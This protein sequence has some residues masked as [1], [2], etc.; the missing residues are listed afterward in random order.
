MFG[1]EA[2]PR[3]PLT[4]GS[5]FLVNRGC[6]GPLLAK[7]LVR[8]TVTDAVVT[9]TITPAQGIQHRIGLARRKDVGIAYKRQ[10]KKP[11]RCV[12]FG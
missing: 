1:P 2:V 10:T 11:D 8:V 12:S 6:T 7:L 9:P 4:P 3:A 5:R